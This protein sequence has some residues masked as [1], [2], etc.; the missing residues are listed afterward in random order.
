MRI[1]RSYFMI[2]LLLLVADA[3]PG[4]A[5]TAGPQLRLGTGDRLGAATVLRHEPIFG[6]GPHT[7]WRGGW[8]VEVE[9]ESVGE[10]TM[11]PVEVL[12]GVTE[13]L[14]VTAVLPFAT[15]AAGGDLGEVGLRAKWR[16]ATRFSPGQMDAL[17]ILGGVAFPR[18]TADGAPKGGAITMLG[19]AM[20]RESRRWYYFAGV[21]GIARLS[22]EGFDPGDRLAVN[23]AWGIRPRRTE[24][25]APDL[26]LLVEANGIAEGRSR[27]GEA[28][29]GTSGGRRLSLAPAV[30][31][32]IRNVMLKG[33]VNIPVWEDFNDP[34]RSAPTEI[35]A[36]VEVHW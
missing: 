21:R 20:G 36:A 24:Y 34:A 6:V 3:T 12:Y 27:V 4:L 14:T 19:L 2:G 26:V 7:T 11:L 17:A 30:L 32:S 5:Q 35:I 15:P 9:I 8:G 28:F 10:E 25:L 16:F 13:E 31:F 18:S 23:I 29:V 33:G 1:Q 22:D